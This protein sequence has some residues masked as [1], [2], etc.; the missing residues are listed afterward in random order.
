MGMM[1][2]D[3]RFRIQIASSWFVALASAGSG[4]GRVRPPEG[5]TTNH[6]VAILT[7]FPVDLDFEFG[8]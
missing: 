3:S 7:H 6:G 1:F 4:R 2:S 5:V 8:I